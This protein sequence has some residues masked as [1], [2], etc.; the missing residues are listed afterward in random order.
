MV[1]RWW[2]PH[3]PEIGF[4]RLVYLHDSIVSVKRRRRDIFK[5]RGTVGR[6]D[7]LV[8]FF[9]VDRLIETP[10]TL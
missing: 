4:L 2:T 5:R 9:A 1:G 8:L 7:G 10:A 3:P 6:G